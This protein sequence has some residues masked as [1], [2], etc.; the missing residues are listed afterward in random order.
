MDDERIDEA[1]ALDMMQNQSIIDHAESIIEMQLLLIIFFYVLSRQWEEG[2]KYGEG[3]KEPPSDPILNF[4]LSYYDYSIVLL[5][6]M[7]AEHL[8]TYI[9]F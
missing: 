5:F 7:F 8:I 6:L 4:G 1:N 2:F 9:F 3:V